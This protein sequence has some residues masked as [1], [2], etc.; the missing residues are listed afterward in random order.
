ME[1]WSTARVVAPRASEIHRAGG[2]R[3]VGRSADVRVRD[4]VVRHVRVGVAAVGGDVAGA[5]DADVGLVE[6]RARALAEDEVDGAVDVATRVHLVAVVG[7]DGVLVPDELDAVVALLVALRGHGER[8]APD[9][10]RVLEVDVVHLQAGG[11]RAQRRRQV[12]LRHL[13][14]RQ[15]LRDRHRVRAVRARV[16]R[17]AVHRQLRLAR[18]D[19]HLLLVGSLLAVSAGPESGEGESAG[20]SVP[21]R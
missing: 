18:G 1:G 8:L 17:V 16:R 15:R 3:D 20:G 12:V 9:A 2:D 6:V 4:N 19:V 21:G 14:L 10:A 13:V 11:V 5:L 7:E